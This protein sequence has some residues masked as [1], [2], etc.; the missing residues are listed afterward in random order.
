MADCRKFP[1]MSGYAS[2]RVFDG[3]RPL[4]GER[5]AAHLARL[6]AKA[7]PPVSPEAPS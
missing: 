3:I 7:P 1:D 2:E 5:K 6:K 4:D